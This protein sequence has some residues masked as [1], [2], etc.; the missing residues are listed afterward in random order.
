MK[1]K[2][3]E[4]A[5]IAQQTRYLAHAPFSKFR[6]GAALITRDGQIYTGCNIENSSFGLTICAERVAV[7]NAISSGESE[8]SAIAIVSDDTDFTT[9]CGACRQVLFDLAGDIDCV[10]MDSKQRYKIIKLSSLLPLAFTEKKLKHV[11]HRKQ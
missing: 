8:F 10:M 11:H 7:F 9:P 6:V 4:L 3:Q 1:K 5:H 2:Y